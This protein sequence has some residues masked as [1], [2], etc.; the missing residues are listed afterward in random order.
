MS[1]DEQP[2]DQEALAQERVSLPAVIDERPRGAIEVAVH[3]NEVRIF[4]K[5]KAIAA[6]AGDD[7]YYRFPARNKDGTTKWIEG[8]SIKCCNAV[9]RVYGNN[10]TR[11]RS[12]DSGTHWLFTAQFYDFETGYVLERQFQQR[13]NQKTMKTDADRQ[14]DIVFQ[15]GQ[16]KAIRNVVNNALSEFT[17]YAFMEAQQGVVQKV[18]Q[19]MKAYLER[20][21]GRLQEL[22]VDIK[23][24]ELAAG[25]SAENWL[26]PDIARTI[27]E[28]QSCNDGMASPDD[29]WPSLDAP[30]SAERPKR[31]DFVDKDTD[32]EVAPESPPAQGEKAPV[33][34]GGSSV[35]AS[36]AAQPTPG[37][38]PPIEK[39][40]RGRPA[41]TAKE[42]EARPEASMPATKAATVAGAPETALQRGM[43]LLIMTRRAAD[44]T[45]LGGTIAEELTPDEFAT[46]KAACE[47]RAAELG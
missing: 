10:A 27:A 6:A 1:Q 28:I 21:K 32:K 45:D 17:D 36:S 40:K 24:V 35:S 19:N 23:R 20:V 15:I 7:F 5:L 29:I 44:V 11:I 31:A 30:I 39:P 38:S 42:P 26:A 8:P 47:R 4:Q 25:R 33:E 43:R 3:R 14:L 37:P 9:A 46:W 22:G 13:K 18:G 16:S 34:T 41:K 2:S 12:Q